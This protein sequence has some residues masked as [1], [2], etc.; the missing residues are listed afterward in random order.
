MDASSHKH[1][2]VYRLTGRRRVCF[3]CLAKKKWRH[4]TT[5]ILL[6]NSYSCSASFRRLLFI[7]KGALCITF[8]CLYKPSASSF[9]GRRAV[10][11]KFRKQ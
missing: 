5:T 11:L 4:K 1:H 2:S 3:P 10:N 9:G 7:P 6:P 8:I